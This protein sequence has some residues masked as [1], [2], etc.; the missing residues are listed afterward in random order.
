M[1]QQN[2]ILKDKLLKKDALSAAE[3]ATLTAKNLEQD[4]VVAELRDALE[5]AQGKHGK[6]WGSKKRI[7]GRMG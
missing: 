4:K 1:K 6:N 3:A 7:D 5:I 2:I